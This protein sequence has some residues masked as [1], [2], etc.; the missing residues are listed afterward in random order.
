MMDIFRVVMT[1]CDS[2]QR[3][4]VGG[5]EQVPRGIWRCPAPVCAHW[6]AGTSLA[7]LHSGAPRPGVARIARDADGR[8]AVTDAW[9][10]TRRYSAVLVTCQGW[11]LTTQ[12]EC[13]EA[14]FSPKIW[15]ALDRTRY[16]QSSKMCPIGEPAQAKDKDPDTGRDVI[17]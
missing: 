14:L 1:N 6:P 5:A 8:L 10:D 17:S 13:E 7:S 4:V 2:D 15:T 12:I 16:M 11:L 3:L 9:G